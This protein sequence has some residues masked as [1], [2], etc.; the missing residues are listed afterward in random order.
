MSN[1]LHWF[2]LLAFKNSCSWNMELQLPIILP[3]HALFIIKF[4]ELAVCFGVVVFSKLKIDVSLL[5]F[6]KQNILSSINKINKCQRHKNFCSGINQRTAAPF[7]T[8]F[9]KFVVA[10]I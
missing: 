9:K 6:S 4:I 8:D 10:L 7:G 2:I 3:L 1:V 5:Q